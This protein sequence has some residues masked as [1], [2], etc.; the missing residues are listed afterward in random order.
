MTAFIVVLAMSFRIHR[1]LIF[2]ILMVSSVL[3]AYTPTAAAAAAVSIPVSVMGL[4]PELQ[5]AI[6]VD[7]SQQGTITGGG[8]RSFKVDKSK[9]H[10]FSVEAEIR[11]QCASYEG[12]SV[13]TRYKCP[14]NVWNLDVITTQNCQ[15]V[16]V[17]YE[18]YVCD[19]WGCWWDYYCSYQQQCWT[20]SELSEKGHAFEYYAEYQVIISDVHGQNLD[21]WVREGADVN[22]STDQFIP[23][24]DESSIKERDIFQSWIVNGAPM[25]NRNLALKVD[26]P[27]YIRAE[28]RTETQVRVRVF[29]EFGH[30]MIDNPD[31]W[32][33]T[34]QESTVSIERELPLDGFWGMLGGKR[35]FVGWQGPGGIESR[36]PT[37]SFTVNDPKDIRAEWTTDTSTP[38]FWFSMLAALIVII[39]VALVVF[40]LYRRGRLFKPTGP[41]ELDKAKAEIEQLKKEIEELKATKHTAKKR[42][43]PEEEPGS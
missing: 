25:E 9:P 15:N 41:S 10:T 19:W 11:G 34:G 7:G 26:K 29:S 1:A 31:G 6:L 14:N 24:R 13:C 12:R 36:E 33:I 40:A 8:T 18:V 37:Y 20:T 23:I 32:Y 38:M 43:P 5:T 42:P 27:Y 22:L 30:P 2:C 17:C 3:L 21:N 4:P 16:P 35:V 28:Y 39:I